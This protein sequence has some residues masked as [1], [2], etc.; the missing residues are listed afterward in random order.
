MNTE[1]RWSDTD[2]AKPNHLKK[3]LP[4]ISYGLTG[5]EMGFSGEGLA[6]DRL[7]HGTIREM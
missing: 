2:R 1:Q 4:Q 3:F 6:S 5:I 7:S